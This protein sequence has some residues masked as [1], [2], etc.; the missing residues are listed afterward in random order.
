MM[1]TAA[2]TYADMERLQKKGIL[3]DFAA[4]VTS[5]QTIPQDPRKVDPPQAGQ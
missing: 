4:M 2:G 5:L 1:L 3:D